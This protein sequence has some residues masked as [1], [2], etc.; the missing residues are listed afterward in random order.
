MSPDLDLVRSILAL[1]Q[2]GDFSETRWAHPDIEFVIADGPD[3]TSM[4]GRGAMTVAWREFLGAFAD[5]AITADEYRELEGHRVYV[6]LHASG[7]G[8]ASG[9]AI[10]GQHGANAFE[11]RGGLV[12]RLAVYFDYRHALEDLGL[13]E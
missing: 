1:W 2:R 10:G 4:V 7:R 11:I 12:T 3:A 6:R 5:Y 13:P 9:A 8:K